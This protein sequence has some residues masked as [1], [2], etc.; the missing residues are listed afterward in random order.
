MTLHVHIGQRV[1][2][3]AMEEILHQ[4]D[5]QVPDTTDFYQILVDAGDTPAEIE[6]DD[7]E[8][9]VHGQDEVAGAIDPLAIA[10]RL[11]TS[12]PRTMP[13]SSTVWC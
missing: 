3:E 4:F 6:R 12:W 5:F 8:R 10:E 7:G 2:R 13:M 1:L 11:S 9:L